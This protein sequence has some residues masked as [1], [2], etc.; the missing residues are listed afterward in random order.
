[1]PTAIERHRRRLGMELADRIDIHVSVSRPRAEEIA[2]PPGEP[3]AAVRGRVCAARARQQAR[4]GAGRC[5]AEMTA[6]E[7]RD[8]DLDPAASA[9]L[10]DLYARG[11]LSRRAHDRSLRLAR[12]LADL[13]GTDRIGEEEMAGALRLMRRDHV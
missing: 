12:T 10:A 3:S 4:L 7:A 11:R 13:A 6:V 1:M 9:L 8:C 5:N 2:G